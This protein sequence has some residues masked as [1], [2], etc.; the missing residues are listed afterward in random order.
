MIKRLFIVLA[1]L[2]V[3]YSAFVLVGGKFKPVGRYFLNSEISDS[4]SGGDLYTLCLVE[5][6][7]DSIPLIREERAGTAQASTL[8]LMGDSFMACNL[9]SDVL[10]NQLADSTGIGV[11][12]IP[13]LAASNF[14]M[15]PLP[16]FQQAG[17]PKGERRILI[18]ET[19][20]RNVLDFALC[21]QTFSAAERFRTLKDLRR[22][23][24]FNDD[25]DYFFRENRFFFPVYKGILN[26]R[27]HIWGEI[28]AQ[29][30]R[31]A[32]DPPMLFFA[33]AVNFNL[34]P[35]SAAELDAMAEMIAWLSQELDAQFNIELVYLIMPNKYSIYGKDID[36][37]YVYDGF[38]P[39]V[40][41]RLAARGIPYIDAYGA[42]QAY[43]SKD[44]GQ[45]L[46]YHS[47]TH[48]T[49]FGKQV[50]LNEILRYLRP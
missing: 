18:L 36:P 12:E 30:G 43:R 11:F 23:I 31:H 40:Q 25:V 19:V 49:P 34:R 9:A 16:Y 5:T 32:L 1:L 14:Q 39:A 6:Y 45:L 8:L 47:D 7:R 50:V 37:D 42:Y 29:I 15:N 3:L 24:F 10:A 38:I 26:A 4:V 28:N 22:K 33:D 35:K 27:F 20:E 17:L 41:E 44:D 48:F 2:S 46:Y 13:E 21:Y